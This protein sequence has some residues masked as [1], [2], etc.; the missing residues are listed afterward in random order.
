MCKAAHDFERTVVAASDLKNCTTV[1][2]AYNIDKNEKS[3]KCI[4]DAVCSYKPHMAISFPFKFVKLGLE[5]LFFLYHK[6]LTM[7]GSLYLL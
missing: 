2:C 6:Q 4:V 1:N 3:P 5:M 7:E